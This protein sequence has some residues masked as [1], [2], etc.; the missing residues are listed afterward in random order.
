MTKNEIRPGARV[1]CTCPDTRHTGQ[2]VRILVPGMFVAVHWDGQCLHP[3]KGTPEFKFM[4]DLAKAHNIAMTPTA[5]LT[6]E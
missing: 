6:A 3:G 2:V 4:K 5:Q 1:A